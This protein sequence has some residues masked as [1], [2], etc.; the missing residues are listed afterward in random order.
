MEKEN[1]YFS[2]SGILKNFSRLKLLFRIKGDF[3]CD[4]KGKCLDGN[5]LTGLLPTGDGREGGLF[6][7]WISLKLPIITAIDFQIVPN[8]VAL[9]QSVTITAL[10]T[11]QPPIATDVFHGIDLLFL[12]PNGNWRQ[13]G[14]ANSDET[15][16]ITFPPIV[17][18]ISG[19]YTVQLSY[20]GETFNSTGDTYKG[21][22][23]SKLL[24]VK[25]LKEPI[26][27]SI[28]I[29]VKPRMDD[30]EAPKAIAIGL[31]TPKPP[32]GELFHNVEAKITQPDGATVTKGPFTSTQEGK[33]EVQLFVTNSLQLGDYSIKLVYKGEAFSKGD[34]YKASESTAKYTV[35]QGPQ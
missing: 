33:V 20:P 2:T 26:S 15:G 34:T 29:T 30:Y 16:K 24:L 7:S 4:T 32:A 21:S 12:D 1:T 6:E 25:E 10:I 17:P 23:L 13:Y 28:S 27:T 35:Y 19:S 11:P 22:T 31:I 8:S 9:G 14:Q 18:D 3:V 5:F